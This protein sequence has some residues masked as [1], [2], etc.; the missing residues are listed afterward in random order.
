VLQPVY[1]ATAGHDGRVSIEVDPRLA[2]DTDATIEAARRLWATVDRANALIKIPA[3]VEGLPAITAVLA[4]GINV[5]VTLIFSLERYRAV[6]NAFLSGLERARAAG[7][8]VSGIASVASFF[9]S[10]LDT[11]VDKRLTAIG[12]PQALALRGKAAVA[13]ARLAYQAFQEVCASSR[14]FLLAADGARPQRPLWAS[15]GVKNPAYPDTLYVTELVARDTVNTMPRA[16]LKAVADHGQVTGNTVRKRY[17]DAS[18][19]LDSLQ[20]EGVVYADVTAA[21]EDEGVAKFERS[22]AELRATLGD[23]LARAG[24]H[25][26]EGEADLE[27]R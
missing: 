15:T 11:E 13:N 3:T 9:V 7:H 26:T 25:A 17:Q 22:W 27:S 5:N 8:D 23:E 10:R 12:T 14:W 2:R 20:R 1:R 21:L 24:V 16:T 18:A 6:M 19:V 4:E